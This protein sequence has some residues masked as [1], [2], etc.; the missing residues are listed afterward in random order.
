MPI[1]CA[2]PAGA[3][4][5]LALAAV[6]LLLVCLDPALAGGNPRAPLATPGTV[7]ALAVS[8]GGSILAATQDPGSI[9]PGGA[10]ADVDTWHLWDRNGNRLN[11]G[12]LDLPGCGTTRVGD[13]CR[14][15]AVAAS[16]SGTGERFAV[17]ANPADSPADNTNGFV[18]LGTAA[19]G[20]RQRFPFANPLVDVQ[21]DA[22]GA[23]L[24][25]VERLPG[26]GGAE[27]A[28]VQLWEW[29]GTA[30]APR[31]VFSGSITSYATAKAFR[32]AA[33]SA[34]GAV[35][36][37]A[38][39]NVQRY[40]WGNYPPAEHTGETAL[41]VQVAVGAGGAHTTAVGYDNGMVQLFDDDHR[42][43]P[44]LTQ[45][46]GT[47]NVAVAVHQEGQS[48]T[49]AAGDASGK[50]YLYTS[51][52]KPDG[53]A[54]ASLATSKQAGSEA[55]LQLRFSGDGRTLVA[56]T[57]SEVRAFQVVGTT[58]TELWTDRPAAAPVAVATDTM[59]DLV[60][61]AAGS[62]VVVY[63]A[64]H[65]LKV[66]AEAVTML[67]KTER[68]IAITFRNEGNRAE[69]VHL[70]T[71]A[72]NGWGF[73]VAPADF[74]IAVGATHQVKARISVPAGQA[75]GTYSL[76]VG[77]TAASGLAGITT[78]A[79]T[80][81]VQTQ[82]TLV[83]DGATSV[84][85]KPGSTVQLRARI[86]NRGNT[87][88]TTRVSAG[89]DL[90]GW[91][92]TTTPQEASVPA[93]ATRPVLVTITA[94]SGAKEGDRGHIRLALSQDPTNVLDMYATVGAKFAVGLTLPA[95]LSLP[96]GNTTTVPVRVS[97]GGNTIDS[98]DLAIT[99]LPDGWVAILDQGGS[100]AE[101]RDLGP[102]ESREA[103]MF[104]RAPS[105][106][107][108]GAQA[109]L[110]VRATSQGDPTQS[111]ERRIQ[112]TVGQPSTSTTKGGPGPE[113]AALLAGLALLALLRRR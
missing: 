54:S 22:T 98:F 112:V 24:A 30:T 29:D 9:V 100:T 16:I 26:V 39:G 45:R 87:E 15:P 99:G 40:G 49:V 6:V 37:V 102:G 27:T 84:S 14:T 52:A 78:I 101:V 41:P 89:V 69:T 66:Q 33:L 96:A 111:Q 72:P 25:T 57:A 23:R 105:D 92:A 65:G 47:G 67:P 71:A 86:E 85:I 91:S 76:E 11:A 13:T 63:D 10:A 75:A 20:L 1:S 56:R 70:A 108:V 51:L 34:D 68:E 36:V 19:A 18:A 88:V 32:H 35:F 83:E 61:V 46:P 58:L 3:V 81:P 94:A 38:A 95:G 12:S 82:I 44:Y 103:T 97:N 64:L 7:A 62:G 28:Q 93:N 55:I 109:K 59:A 50:L 42:A 17:A 60:A 80:V 48:A 21:L 4:Q 77:H 104:L 90:P 5:R 79:V 8:Q 43:N 74:T 110:G 107:E 113:A 73:T 106:A 2:A 53:S 31:G